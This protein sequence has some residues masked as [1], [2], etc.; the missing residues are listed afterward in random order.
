[1]RISE[2]CTS[3]VVCVGPVCTVREAAEIMR[4]NHVGSVVVVADD[5]LRQ[6][7][8]GLLTDRDIAISVVAPGIL[9]EVV[10]VGDVMSLPVYTFDEDADLLDATRCMRDKGVRR[11]VV[12]TRTGEVAG[13]LTLDDAYAAIT[14]QLTDLKR[15]VEREQVR[16]TALRA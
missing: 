4:K 1:M 3:N 8:I 6:T 13:I 7:P 14:S 15:V 12:T 9:P 16:E 10:T 11:L 2:V 5:M